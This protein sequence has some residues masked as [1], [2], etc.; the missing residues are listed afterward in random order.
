MRQS[1]RQ[2]THIPQPMQKLCAL[3]LATGVLIGTV[4][5]GNAWITSPD[6]EETIAAQMS[7]AEYAYDKSRFAEAA[8][9]FE[10]V[11]KKDPT[12]DDARVK[13]AYAL[14]AEAGLSILDF[15][16]KFITEEDTDSNESNTDATKPAGKT[17]Q[18]KPLE[19]LTSTVGLSQN[20][21]A[22]ISGASPTTLADVRQ[23]SQ[24]FQKLQQSWKT[25]CNLMPA[26]LFDTVF[27]AESTALQDVFEIKECQDGRPDDTPVRSA[28][29]FAATM[30]FM[31]Q[32]AGLFQASLDTDGNNEID[33]AEAGAK[34]LAKLET[35]QKNANAI[36]AGTDVAAQEYSANL[37]SISEELSLLRNLKEQLNGEIVN[38]TLACFTFV[39]ALTALIPNIP[40]NIA[41]RI[42]RAATR[43]NEG[44][45]KLVQ[46]SEFSPSS[47]NAEQGKKVKE[48]A[49]KAA[50]TIDSL[51][52]KVNALPDGKEKDERKAALDSQKTQVCSNFSTTKAEFN[53]PADI[54]EPS[55]CKGVIALTAAAGPAAELTAGKHNHSQ[56]FAKQRAGFAL[57]APVPLPSELNPSLKDRFTNAE[58]PA[59]A[60]MKRTDRAS[61]EQEAF[62]EF[63]LKGEELQDR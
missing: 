63:A 21:V 6:R 10:E 30:Q 5:C 25:I 27:T 2:K 32:A 50:A 39:T 58:G 3:A 46:Y 33:L 17:S 9:L 54:S 60:R 20:E 12:Y 29:L 57:F 4:S 62:L 44:R 42:E 53:L 56:A 43:I 61:V 26:R 37:A 34:S 40:E 31:A 14:N 15:V 52:A 47:T 35:L 8:R 19:I 49:S 28:A 38:Y 16:T 45:T 51:Y 7:R 48:A 36:A 11:L 41:M 55:E 22:E 18:T 59:A 1:T 23:V 24:K 13:L